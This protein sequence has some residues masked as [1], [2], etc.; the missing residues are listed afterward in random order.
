MFD[1]EN[2]NMSKCK[3]E[4]C[5]FLSEVS[6]ISG[7]IPYKKLICRLSFYE[8]FTECPIWNR[9]MMDKLSHRCVL[10]PVKTVPKFTYD[11]PFLKNN[12]SGEE[13]RVCFDKDKDF[14]KLLRW[15]EDW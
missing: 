2:P 12:D 15:L 13:I 8:R 7:D 1:I 10:E 6:K 11:F 3:R 5:Y 9:E 14:E 4:N